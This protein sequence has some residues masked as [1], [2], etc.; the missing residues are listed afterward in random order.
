M[1]VLE[2][3]KSANDL[4][5]QLITLATGV[6][7]LSITFMREAFKADRPTW[8]LK[9]SWVMLLLS[10]CFGI[11]TMMA[12]TGSLF[13]ITQHPEQFKNASYG[14]N[15]YV[16]SAIQILTFVT[17]IISL[18]IYSVRP[19]KP[20]EPATGRDG[21][22][23]VPFHHHRVATSNSAFRIAAPAAPRMVLWLNVTKR[24]SST[25]SGRKRPTVT[26]MPAPASRSK[27]G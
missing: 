26:L 4:T 17:G 10:V 15:I 20:A 23:R 6:L 24:K 3:F 13:Q 8:A 27:R 1:E 12:I 9:C 2:G 22:P 11:W 18:I 14:S 7:A 25:L 16:P 19:P 21:K 5:I